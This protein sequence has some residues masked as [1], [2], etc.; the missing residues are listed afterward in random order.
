VGIKE[1]RKLEDAE[2]DGGGVQKGSTGIKEYE[3]ICGGLTRRRGS[4]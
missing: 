3:N 2:G 4:S 1:T